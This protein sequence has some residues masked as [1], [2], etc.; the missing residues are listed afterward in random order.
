MCMYN[1]VYILLQDKILTIIPNTQKKGSFLSE[2]DSAG[3]G[4]GSQVLNMVP[5]GRFWA[6]TT[7]T[8]NHRA[9]TKYQLKTEHGE[10]LRFM[11]FSKVKL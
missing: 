3:A 10:L 1:L 5:P 6:S 11:T 4:L 9:T 8:T 7:T 2:R